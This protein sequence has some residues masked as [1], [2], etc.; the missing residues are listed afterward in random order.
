MNKQEI[1]RLCND[2]MY[3][4]ELKYLDKALEEELKTNKSIFVRQETN[5]SKRIDEKELFSENID[6]TIKLLESLKK[7]G[8]TS[9]SQEWSGYESIYFVADKYSLE[10]DR[11]YGERIAKHLHT[12]IKIIEAKEEEIKKVEQRI[13][14]YEAVLKKLKRQ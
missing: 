1:K 8:Y 11:E 14:E 12:I 3:S 9:I 7:K 4:D 2:F 5:H 13:K 6:D 10:T